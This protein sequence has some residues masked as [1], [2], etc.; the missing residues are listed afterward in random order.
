MSMKAESLAFDPYYSVNYQPDARLGTTEQL[1]KDEIDAR[2]AKGAPMVQAQRDQLVTGAGAEVQNDD[3]TPAAVDFGQPYL[4][5][6]DGPMASLE[7]THKAME[8]AFAHWEV[9]DPS[10]FYHALLA[11]LE[12]DTQDLK[13]MKQLKHMLQ[14]QKISAKRGEI[15]YTADKIEAEQQ[16]A[17]EK[18]IFALAATGACVALGCSTNMAAISSIMAVSQ[19]VNAAGDVYTKH[20]GGELVANQMDIAAKEEGCEAE[21]VDQAVEDK[22]TSETERRELLKSALKLFE[23]HIELQKSSSDAVAKATL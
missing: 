8:R 14:D 13:A 20:V 5:D 4:P 23:L 12:S 3:G 17:V 7:D 11:L 15:A 19:L 21:V 6:V 10:L 16:A 2:L 22:K 1:G 18:L 9:T